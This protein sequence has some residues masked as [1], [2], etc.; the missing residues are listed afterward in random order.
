[1]AFQKVYSRINWENEPSKE[2]PINEDNLNKMDYALNEIDGRVVELSGYQEVAKTYAEQ[3]QA[4]AMAS[5]N[6]STKAKEHEDNTKTYMKNASASASESQLSSQN[7]S[8]SE[9]S[10]KDYSDSALESKNSA[11]LSEINA[12][13][14]QQLAKDS[15]EKALGYM[16]NAKSSEDNAKAS[17]E[18]AVTMAT[19]S[20]EYSDLAKSY[21]VGTNGV[22][23]E[24]DDTDNAKY[25]YEETKKL[26]PSNMVTSV[27]GRTGDVTID[28]AGVGLDKVENKSAED[29]I[30]EIPVA[31]NTT[32]G[33]VKVDN[34]TIIIDEDGTLHG[35]SKIDIATPTT[36][37]TVKPDNDTITIDPDGTLHGASSKA[38]PMPK[39]AYNALSEEEKL[40]GKVF[41]VENAES[42]EEP[43]SDASMMTYDDTV[44][45]LGKSVQDAI[46]NANDKIEQNAE[47]IGEL[48]DNLSEL[49][50]KKNSTFTLANTSA[51]GS[52]ELLDDFR[53]YNFLNVILVTSDNYFL[54]S[55]YIP[56]EIVEDG[57]H[58]YPSYTSDSQIVVYVDVI[59]G[60]NFAIDNNGGNKR[61]I[62][63]GIDRKL[64]D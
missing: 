34:D 37:G 44:S 29:I 18:V 9:Q 41:Y 54:S 4:S 45:G 46:D 59:N 30:G 33:K 61:V 8:I 3:S 2:T 51:N 49:R 56:T 48:N 17:E 15:E 40:S 12:L 42:T 53:N 35:A 38:E 31:T 28:K 62:I 64:G 63:V 52:V 47:D 39:S 19:E 5:A 50:L 16:N 23:R 10:A 43:T 24:N 11:E 14:S 13:S 20:I 22:V 25:Y 58:L 32:L 60:R 57:A 21:A 7:A 6:S 26:A 27:N 36:V 55:I 1:M